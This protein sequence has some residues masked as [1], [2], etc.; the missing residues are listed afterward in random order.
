MVM[1]TVS[2]VAL[3]VSFLGCISA[4]SE[5]ELNFLK[6]AAEGRAGDVQKLHE[7]GVSLAVKDDEGNTALHKAAIGGHP[8]VVITHLCIATASKG[9][10]NQ[11]LL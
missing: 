10:Y 6:A 7:G 8:N 2:I 5:T 9:T 3:I 4:L 11:S 1:K